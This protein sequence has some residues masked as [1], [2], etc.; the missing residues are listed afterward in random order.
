MMN[1]A[2]GL[3][4]CFD[5]LRGILEVPEAEMKAATDGAALSEA[6]VAVYPYQSAEVGD[7][8]FQQG[9]QVTVIKKEG[10]WW[11]GVIGDRVGIFPSNYVMPD[12]GATDQVC[13][14]NF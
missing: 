11:T 5:C 9:E 6:Y 7:L 10:D 14:S 12:E 2:R 13:I 8:S 4:Q 1:I 3:T